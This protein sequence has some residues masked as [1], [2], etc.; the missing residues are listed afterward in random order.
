[1]ELANRL[2]V[3]LR[4]LGLAPS[5]VV[6]TKLLQYLKLLQKWN[7]VYNL[8]AVRDPHE[9]V[10]R[11][12]LDSLAIVPCIKGCRVADIGTGAGLPGIPLALALPEIRFVLLDRSAKKARFVLQ[13]VTELGL[14]NVDVVRE[15][16]EQYQPTQAFDTLVTR[17]LAPIADVLAAAGHLCADGGRIL[18]MKGGYP[19]QELA[20]VPAHY[21]VTEVQALRVPGLNAKRHLVV[22]TRR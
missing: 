7:R 17:A 12:I 2:A 19:T 10:A 8:T 21:R 4:A 5:P 15:R 22:I 3:G 1:M 11:H 14:S 9:M 18:I 13:A 6:H 16:A 20:S